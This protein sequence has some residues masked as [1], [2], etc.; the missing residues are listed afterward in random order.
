MRNAVFSF[1][2]IFITTIG[3]AQETQRVEINGRIN[4]ETEDKEGITVYNQSSNKG[5][6]T[7]ENGAFKI[8]V[9]ENDI[10]AFG[11]LQFKDFTITIDKR[12]IKSR[13][14]SVRLVEEVNKLDEVIVLPYD[15]SGN[16]NVDV[17]AVRTYNVEMA[18]IYKGQE[19]FDDYKF[20]ADNKT[21]IDDPLLDENRFRNGLNIANLFKLF[22]K[23]KGAPKTEVEIFEEKQ[24]LIA[25]RYS[26]NFLKDNFKIPTDLTEAFIEYIENKGY[27]KSLLLR[28]NEIFL[29]EFLEKES[30]LFLLSRE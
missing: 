21:K 5:V 9:A 17:E 8:D 4:V 2:L 28:K 29:I 19:D 10:L 22:L 30:Q 15:L 7:D 27:E 16:I 12:I 6:T 13:Q 20:S 11:A 18:E 26:A 1:I 25:K 14:V 3:Y 23:K 24:S